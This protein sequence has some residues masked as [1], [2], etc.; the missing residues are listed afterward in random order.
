MTLTVV[1]DAEAVALRAAEIV[2]EL[3]GEAA[4]RPPGGRD[5]FDLALSGGTTPERCHELLAELVDDWSHVHVWLSD[6]RAV[7]PDDDDSNFKMLRRSLLDRIRIPEANVHRVLG[8]L[9][10]DEAADRYEREVRA[11]VVAG[12]DGLP[13]FDAIMCGMGPDGH[14]CS[15]FP[16]HP[17]VTIDDRLVAPVHGAPKP[18]PDRVTFTFPLLHAASRLLLV[19]TGEAKREAMEAVCAGV[20]PRVPASLLRLGALEAI[21]DEAA[22]PRRD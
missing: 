11:Q 13:I 10:A 8:E 1:P 2:A 19:V 15:L 9:G 4:A 21:V 18:P 7:P 20:D 5:R 14:T 3:A 22:A 12:P 16:G 17:A 6:E